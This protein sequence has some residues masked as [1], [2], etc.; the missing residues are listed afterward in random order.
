M[1]ATFAILPPADLTGLDELLGVG[2]RIRAAPAA[3]ILK[4]P[5]PTILL[6]CVRRG[7]YQ[8]PT[9]ELI[10]WLRE[11]VGS[12]SAVEV[13]SGLGAIGRSLGIERTDN[14][15]QTWA[16][17]ERYYQMIGQQ[18]ISPPLDVKMMSANDAVRTLRPDVVVGAW[19][20][21]LYRPGDIDGNQ[22]GVDEI[23]ICRRV[24]KYIHIGNDGPH[25]SKRVNALPHKLY[26][27]PWLVSRAV[28]QSKNHVRVWCK[29]SIS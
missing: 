5:L 19:A 26:R 16:E 17:I 7:V 22:W 21:Q 2:G 11:E 23:E 8:L 9:Q 15:M 27:F 1:P 4:F 10:D 20:T 24:K 14:Y 28:D 12:S 6:W 29:E 13:C 3:E 25:G 18:P